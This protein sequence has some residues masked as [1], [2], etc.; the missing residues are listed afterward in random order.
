ML[1]P[2]DTEQPESDH[3]PDP[4]D[5]TRPSTP[6]PPPSSLTPVPST[7]ERPSVMPSTP[8]PR[9]RNTR[10]VDRPPSPLAASDPPG[11]RADRMQRADLLWEME[12]AAPRRSSRTPV[13]NP[14]YCG[15]DNAAQRGRG[16]RLGFAELL[17]AALVGR[18]PATYAEAMRSAD[19]EAWKEACQYEIDAMARN[20]AWDLVDL[21]AGHKA[22][23][24]KWVFKLKSDGRFRARLVAKGF[25]QVPGIDYDETFSPVARF[26]SL[27]LLLALAALGD[28][29]IH[30][31]DVKSAFLNGVLEEEIFMEKPQGFVVSGQ[32]TRVCRLKKALYDLKQ[33]SRAWNIQFHGVL[34]ELGFTQTYSDAGV[35]VYHQHG[36]D[37]ILVVILYVDDIT[38]HLWVR[39]WNI[40]S[41]LNPRS[42][43]ATR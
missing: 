41:V 32:E 5:T 9:R 10:I 27:R 23:K 33:A 11:R 20:E 3:A 16:Q 6:T 18:D 29:H 4:A 17:A 38:V 7:P 42:V 21:P 30:Q 28:W 37:G 1:E 13:P 39:R 2:P 25:T 8:P 34:L 12:A 26:E 36:G 35:Y 40:S 22:V 14:C 43:N 24:S 15:P 19:A 31:M